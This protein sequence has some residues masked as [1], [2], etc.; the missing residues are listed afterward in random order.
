MLQLLKGLSE[1]KKIL[2][3]KETMLDRLKTM[4]FK[5][6]DENVIMFHMG[7]ELVM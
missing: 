7:Q 3:K 1:E 6:D 5:K 2:K 4:E